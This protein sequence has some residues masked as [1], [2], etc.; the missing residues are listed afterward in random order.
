MTVLVVRHGLAMARDEFQIQ[1]KDSHDDSRPLTPEGIR[2]MQKNARGLKALVCKP[3]LLLSSPL[4]R[5]QQT[6]EILREAWGGPALSVTELLRPTARPHLL[7]ASLSS[8]VVAA[9]ENPLICIVGHEPHLSKLVTWFL[10]GSGFGAKQRS[11]IELKKGGA[12]LLEF[13]HDIAKAQARLKWLAAP[14]FLKS[15]R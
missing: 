7:A 3:D 12:C 2:K 10:I 14:N 13:P 11:L 4:A 6:A 1:Y 5:A 9:R 15:I 8:Q